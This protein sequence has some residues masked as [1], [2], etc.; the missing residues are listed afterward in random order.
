MN[1]ILIGE[2]LLARNV[3]DRPKKHTNEKQFEIGDSV[4]AYYS[5]VI[6][7]LRCNI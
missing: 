5:L 1:N 2:S 7:L 6:H 3:S 4:T